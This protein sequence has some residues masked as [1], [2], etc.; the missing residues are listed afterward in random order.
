MINTQIATELG[1]QRPVKQAIRRNKSMF[2]TVRQVHLMSLCLDSAR[3]FPWSDC[4][5]HTIFEVYKIHDSKW[6]T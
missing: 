6:G 4:A 3:Q 5:F 1:G 2:A